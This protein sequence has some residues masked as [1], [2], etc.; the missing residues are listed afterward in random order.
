VDRSGQKGV[1]ASRLGNATCQSP[2]AERSAH[3]EQTAH[4]PGEQHP[5]PSPQVC[6]CETRGGEHPDP[7]HVS[8]DQSG[9]THQTDAPGAAV[10]IAHSDPNA[11]FPAPALAC[12][13]R[14]ASRFRL[15]KANRL[16]G[17]AVKTAKNTRARCG[18]DASRPDPR[19]GVPIPANCIARRGGGAP[20]S[21]GGEPP[22]TGVPR[23]STA[24]A[25]ATID[26]GVAA[27]VACSTEAN[28]KLSFSSSPTSSPER[29]THGNHR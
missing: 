4:E 1:L 27:E 14:R 29:S 7:D 3:G 23:P 17:S 9:G 28:P 22:Y 5:L 16:A 25:G 11:A 13:N 2:V 12:P 18:A 19:G 26:N 21:G 24:E 10:A 15:R 6:E 20:R 8:Y